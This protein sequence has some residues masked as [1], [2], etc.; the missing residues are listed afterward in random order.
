MLAYLR[1]RVYMECTLGLY[2]LA[3]NNPLQKSLIQNSVFT[4]PP[5]PPRLYT[6][7]YA[8][9]MHIIVLELD[10]ITQGVSKKC[11]IL[12]SQLLASIKNYSK[13]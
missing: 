4:P 9:T 7:H 3:Y 1:R 8:Q 2:I 13:R 5:P 12:Y 6:S 11:N 10:N